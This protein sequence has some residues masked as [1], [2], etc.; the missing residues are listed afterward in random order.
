MRVLLID[1]NLFWTV[2]FSKTLL[3]LG[4]ESVTAAQPPWPEGPFDAAI[5]N[6]SRS[7]ATK[8]W[9]Q[10]LQAAGTYVIGHAGHKESEKL[11]LG[12]EL[13]CDR[14][15]TNS[16]ITHKLGELLAAAP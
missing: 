1:D 11:K 8:E 10:G 7:G 3:A 5:L 12:N 6:L 13:G 2:R 4:H 15:A 9:V 16:E 14:V